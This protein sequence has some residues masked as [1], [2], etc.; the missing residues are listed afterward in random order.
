MTR[1]NFHTL[2]VFAFTLFI[3]TALILNVGMRLR[4]HMLAQELKGGDT[5]VEIEVIAAP[6]GFTD[7]DIHQ[8]PTVTAK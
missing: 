7:I 8:S 5:V 2:F 4:G 6:F 1:E 3:Y